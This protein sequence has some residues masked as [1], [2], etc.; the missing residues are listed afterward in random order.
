MTAEPE[1]TFEEIPAEPVGLPHE[2]AVRR[3]VEAISR[4]ISAVMDAS[5]ALSASVPVDG[6]LDEI[7][8]YWAER[9][10]LA[11]AE[12]LLWIEMVGALAELGEKCPEWQLTAASYSIQGVASEEDEAVAM[13][14]KYSKRGAPGG[15]L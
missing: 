3:S 10:R 15:E 12:K 13:V 4:S 1:P 7:R 6:P 9:L 5:A 8:A 2:P 14:R 11:G